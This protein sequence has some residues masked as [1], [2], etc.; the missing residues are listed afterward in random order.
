MMK[1]VEVFNRMDV[2]KMPPDAGACLVSIWSAILVARNKYDPMSLDGW[3]DVLRLDFDD[4]TEKHEHTTMFTE[5]QADKLLDFIIANDGSPFVVHCDAGVS[6]S[7]AV[8]SFMRDAFDYKPRFYQTGS[9]QFRNI[10]VYNLLR[11]AWMKR[12]IA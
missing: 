4:V 10:H 8:G 7:V 12:N 5:E 3:K 6:R 11:R 1:K 2:S 9:D